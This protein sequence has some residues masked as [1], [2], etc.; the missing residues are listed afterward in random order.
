MHGIS[1]LGYESF[2][3]FDNDQIELDAVKNQRMETIL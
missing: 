3:R 2:V 1:D